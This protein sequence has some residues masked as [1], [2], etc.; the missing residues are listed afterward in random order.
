M[1]VISNK[2]GFLILKEFMDFISFIYIVYYF[3][4]VLWYWW[5][6]WI[7]EDDFLY[8]YVLWTRGVIC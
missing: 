4:I 2:L 6:L 5:K 1:E 7:F 3:E 8:V